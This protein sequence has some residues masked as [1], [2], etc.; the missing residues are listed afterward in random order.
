MFKPKFVFKAFRDKPN[1][2]VIQR[3][4]LKKRLFFYFKPRSLQYYGEHSSKDL[5]RAAVIQGEFVN[6]VFN[7]Y[8]MDKFS[9]RAMVVLQILSTKKKK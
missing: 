7:D 2:S 4:F 5:T 3:N 8:V 1:R 9:T 6:C